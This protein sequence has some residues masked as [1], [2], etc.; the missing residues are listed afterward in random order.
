MVPFL[1][2]LTWNRGIRTSIIT[3]LLVCLF[4]ACTSI[5]LGVE[6][7][8][9]PLGPAEEL[10][11]FRLAD[12]TLMIELVAAEPEVKSP[13]SIAWDADGFLYVAE[14][15]DYPVAP[16]AGQIRRLEDRDGDGRHEQATVFAQGLAFPNGVLPC[17]GGV[18][19]TAAPDILFLRDRDGDGRADERRVLLTGF[20]AGNTQLRVNGLFWGPDN[21][22]YA[23]NGR[24]DGEVRAPAWPAGKVVSIRRRDVRFRFRPE[25]SDVQVEAIAG[26]SQFGLAHDDWGNRFPSWNTIP[27]R[28]VVLE[29]AALERN[30]FLVETTSV[31]P[32]LDDADGGRVYSIS[33]VQARFNRES[34]EFFNASC[35]PTIFR[36]N[37]LPGEYRGN[38]FVCEPLTNL[39]HRR[40]LEPAACTFRARRVESKR[41]FLASTD[42]SFRPVNLTTG[43]DGALYVVDMYR[44]MVEHPDF[45][46]AELRTS[47]EFRRW[48]DR[49]RLWRIRPRSPQ[50]S[51]TKYD[52]RIEL[53]RASSEELVAHLSDGGGWWRDTA[54]RLLVERQDRRVSSLLQRQVR[55]AANPLARLHALWT[56]EGLGALD[57][58]TLEQATHDSH[59]GLREHALRAS[60]S[61]GPRS[62]GLPLVEVKRLAGDAEIR[63]RLQSALA[64]GHLAAE[65]PA[66]IQPLVSLATRDAADPWMRLA[67]QCGLS[68]SALAFLLEWVTATPEMLGDARPEQLG[69]L[70]EIAAIVGA[71]RRLH[72]LDAL[73]DLIAKRN[74]GDEYRSRSLVG[75]LA[76]LSGLGEGMERSGPA[77]HFWLAERERTGRANL[78][79]L[80]SLWPAARDLAL[81]QGAAE[82][83]RIALQA[84][85]R[86]RPEVAAPIVPRLLRPEQPSLLQAEAAHA[87]GRLGRTDIAARLL[88]TWSEL[89]LGTRRELCAALLASAGTAAVLVA[90]IE[91]QKV[92]PLELDATSRDA[93]LHLGDAVLRKR[94]EVALAGSMPADR[95][96]V[97]SRYRDALKLRGDASRGASVFAKN[98]Q[99]CHLHQGQGHRVGP[100]LSG[101][102]GRP[103][104]V[105]L[106]DILDPNRDVAPDFV[107]VTVATEHGQVVSGLLVEET[108]ASLKLRKA[109]GIDEGILRSEIAEIRSTS[110]SLMPDG[111]EQSLNIQE[112]ADLLAFLRSGGEAQAALEPAP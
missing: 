70:A 106:S 33:P 95:S 79:G 26:F 62:G 24:S 100:D 102:A 110:R 58:S 42:P 65:D 15:I 30:P 13:V 11:S 84:L 21:W 16:P 68:E 3:H 112:M 14:M 32:I 17:F 48:S 108:G 34:V 38:A 18:L 8:S 104:A 1:V 27:L 6:R 89:S 63:V 96:A 41:E 61:P 60:C 97:L 67:I 105:L 88:E 4:W 98:C 28:H 51:S 53:S 101:I 20:G 59:A 75:R 10:A 44:E 45:V 56:L 82:E 93:L 85:V 87:V 77:L 7:P 46:P 57:R 76:L 54:Q 50:A 25:T 52:R 37:G 80:V 9:G 39:V 86:G 90:A 47:I 78:A 69:L 99:T 12:P 94:A 36:G 2:L 55:T 19:V 81:S 71:R 35:G 107:A 83:R 72:E 92:S 111:L 49:G 109:D 66:A 43:P 74:R 31:A 22:I 73:V 40:K 29:E 103:P 5:C 23:A 64:L 91:G